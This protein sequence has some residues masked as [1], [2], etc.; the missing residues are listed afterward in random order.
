MNSEK[1]GMRLLADLM[2]A[3]LPWIET[4]Y[5]ECGEICSEPE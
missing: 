3:K 1:E 5:F 4:K 2:K